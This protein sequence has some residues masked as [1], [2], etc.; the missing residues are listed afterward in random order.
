[1]DVSW[2]FTVPVLK[3]AIMIAVI[4]VALF[5]V[6]QVLRW[7]IQSKCPNPFDGDIRVPRKDYIHDQKKRDAVIKQGFSKD[8][9]PDNLD[10]II[11]GSGIGS[12][13]TAAIMSRA[14]KRVLV[15]E[16]HD[17]AGG[18][19]HTFIDKGYEFDVGIHYIGEMGHQTLNKT[20]LD[21][22]C[23]GQVEWSPLD[24][25][26]DVIQIGYGSDGR[27]YPVATGTEAW[28]SLLK[29]QFPEEE[30]A[31][32][33][34]FGLLDASSKTSTIHGAMKLIPL[35]IVKIVL[36]SGI[37]KY[38]TNIFRPEYTISTL[39]LVESLT[40]NKDL[41]A[42][43]MYCWG[44]YGTP[45]SKSN[46]TMQAALNRHFMKA[47]AHY[48]I[49]GASEIAFNIIPVIEKAGGRV[50][51][52]VPVTE[53][54]A[55]GG[56]V[57]G[58]KVSKGTGT[59][60]ILA[61]MV[62]SSAGLYN[63]FQTL[64]PKEIAAKSY[65]TK[66]CKDLKPGV[67][68]MN[69][70]LG[71]NKS[72]EELGLK[73]QNMWAFTSNELNQI[74]EDYFNLDANTAMDSEIPLLFISFPS[75]KDPE[76]VNHPG[77]EN[78]STC[79]IVT[80]AN[81]EWFQKWENKTIKKRG[82]SYD[83]VKN[84]I[85]HQMIEQTCKLYPQIRDCID[86]TEIG[87]PVTNKYYIAQPHGEIYGLD[88]SIE[89]FDPL[90]VAK[91]RPATDIPGL[92]L[93]GQDILSCGFTGALFAGVLGAQAAL[94]RNVMGDLISLHNKLEG[95]SASITDIRK[96]VYIEDGKKKQ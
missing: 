3:Q 63:T 93:T 69:I 59:M 48:P 56:K 86:F 4:L 81:W 61:P 37:M 77:R 57:C 74:G 84:S 40:S 33:Q 39:Q 49:G 11:I 46:F 6:V 83:E 71:L 62:I 58:V 90:M 27:T 28:K 15:L 29:K 22:I 60:E 94:G 51:V 55:K 80:L 16:Q 45:P 12:L 8:K 23:E 50:L 79:A 42:V 35:W 36:A 88:H 72:K 89:R 67:A 75:A 26:F 95:G 41:Q 68:A 76:W 85:G 54:V 82:D 92:F 87:T 73:R 14:G 64:L 31:I 70:F 91:L 18:C 96:G 5:L 10:A 13:T 30:K 78:K 2:L 38:F 65:Y 43:L 20:L 66:I 24:D 19:C 9:I 44:D 52:R 47:G 53:I 17:Q 25:D 1:M 21:Q 7:S 34:Y 32:N